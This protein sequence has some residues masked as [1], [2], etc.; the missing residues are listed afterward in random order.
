MK[1]NALNSRSKSKF[2]LTFFL[3]VFIVSTLFWLLGA[4]AER[5][6]PED[7]P[8]NILSSLSVVSPTIAALII[9]QRESGSKGVKQL[10][11]R[12]LDYKG[13]KGKAWYGPILFLMPTIMVLAYGLMTLMRVPLPEPQIPV[14]MVPVFLLVFFIAALGEETGWQGYA[15]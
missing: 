13:I 15:I 10:L 7:M 3:L 9:V 8:I 12:S 5:F 1:R 11:K 6:L 4:V 2:P 14:L